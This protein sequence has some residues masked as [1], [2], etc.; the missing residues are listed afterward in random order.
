MGKRETFLAQI[1]KFGRLLY[2]GENLTCEILE[3]QGYSVGASPNGEDALEILRSPRPLPDLIILDML[4]P[5]I[6]GYRFRK[7]Q[8]RDPTLASIPVVAASYGRIST[9]CIPARLRMSLVPS[10]IRA[11]ALS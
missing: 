1:F 4:M 3:A 7:L 11:A 9:N 10:S 6:N 2:A 5:G 8:K